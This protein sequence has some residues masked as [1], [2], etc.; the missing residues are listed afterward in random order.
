MDGNQGQ[1]QDGNSFRDRFRRTVRSDSDEIQ[2]WLNAKGA[3]AF[4]GIAIFIGLY[5]IYALVFAR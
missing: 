4:G 2:D 3:L 1:P 5:A